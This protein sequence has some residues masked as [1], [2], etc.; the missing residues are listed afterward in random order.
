[1]KEGWGRVKGW[2]LAGHVGGERELRAVFMVA[3]I[4]GVGGAP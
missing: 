2:I 1:M 3:A 4:D